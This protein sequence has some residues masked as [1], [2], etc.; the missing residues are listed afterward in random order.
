[1][2]CISSKTVKNYNPLDNNFE[3]YKFF[4]TRCIRHKEN[5]LSNIK[6]P[7]MRVAARVA[8]QLKT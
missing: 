4:S 7:Y 5:L 2:N 3:F 8:E 6:K 1:M